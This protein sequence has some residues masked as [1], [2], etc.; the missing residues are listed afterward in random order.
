MHTF[1]YNFPVGT[2]IRIPE[3]ENNEIGTIVAITIYSSDQ[4]TNDITCTVSGFKDS[5]CKEILYK[6]IS[7]S[8][9]L[10][11]GE[12]EEYV[13][14]INKEFLFNKDKIS[15]EELLKLM[16]FNKTVLSNILNIYL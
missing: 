13:N 15:K 6:S 4:N 2:I 3:S 16:E 12:I 1:N 11:P 9:V 10:S 5:W 14:N 8:N 7:E